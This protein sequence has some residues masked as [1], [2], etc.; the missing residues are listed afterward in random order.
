MITTGSTRSIW[1]ARRDTNNAYLL[2]SALGM[3]LR[4][5]AP[6]HVVTLCRTSGLSRTVITACLVTNCFSTGDVRD[7]T[8]G[9]RSASKLLSNVQVPTTSAWDDARV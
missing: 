5:L 8:I 6:L 3:R 9:G 2:R 7:T 1:R 4:Y